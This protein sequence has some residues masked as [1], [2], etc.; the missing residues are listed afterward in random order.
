MKVLV[1]TT[2][3]PNHLHP[4]NAIFIKQRMFHFARLKDCEIK[5]VAPVPYCPPWPALGKWY[6]NSQIKE[7]EVMDGIEV[8]HPRY[9]L[10]P[11][12][13]MALHGFSLF[14]SSLKLL[15]KI[16]K[17]F[18]FDLID[19]H[20]IYPDGFAA[21]LLGKAMKRPVVLSA[22]GSDIN[23]FTGFKSIKPMIRYALGHAE[24][25]I[26]VCDALKQEMVA[27]GINDDKISVIPNGVDSKQ[28]YPVDKSKARK[29]LSLPINKKI[30][31]SVG[32]LIPR[33]GFHVIIDA[34]PKLLQED[35]NS[36][37]YIIGEGYFRPSLERQ[38][39]A[40]NLTQHVTLV[41]ECPN[42]E[43]KFWYSAADVFC[44]ASS[45]E[46]WANVIMESLACGTPVVATNVW[47][48]PEILTSTGI[49]MLVDR[50]PDAF[51][52][53]L[54]RALETLGESEVW[55]HKIFF[56]KL[57]IFPEFFQEGN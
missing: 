32:S 42:T 9:P 34:F 33:K 8:Y 41:G 1:Y 51:Y 7:Y 38:I 35:S 21:V 36:Y 39:E 29:K 11:K 25:V 2:L 16:N 53:A 3:F 19:G 17:T 56:L 49:G 54:K 43:L 30:I 55:Q 10:I 24:H 27:L 48:A 28:F 12:V 15:K 26:S 50:T 13:S 20:Y 22:R 47:G 18:P 40:L 6:Q 52:N 14:L 31:L 37:L 44:L 5:V 45:R 57:C 46:G 4:N 23:Q